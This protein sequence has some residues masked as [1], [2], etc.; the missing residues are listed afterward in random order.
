MVTPNTMN[1]LKQH[2]EVTGGQVGKTKLDEGDGFNL[3]GL[4]Y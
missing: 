3:L 2:L 1:L 4:T